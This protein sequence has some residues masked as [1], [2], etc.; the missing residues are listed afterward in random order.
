MVGLKE[1]C[2]LIL[3]GGVGAGSV[4]A[5]QQM[6]PPPRA[7][8][9][10]KPKPRPAAQAAAPRAKIEDCPTPVP[11]GALVPEFPV[12]MPPGSGQP[13]GLGAPGG[14]I[15]GPFQSA[16]GL[17]AGPIGR[18]P[19]LPAP[20]PTGVVPEPAAW[21]MMVSGFGLIGLALRRRSPGGE[22]S[23]KEGPHTA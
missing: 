2:A 14:G 5:V 7:A 10:A 21:L 16:P 6:N 1:V 22:G 3:A 19:D 17:V 12:L 11:G 15:G 4:V 9:K 23:Q 20:P 8:K 13:V 18:T